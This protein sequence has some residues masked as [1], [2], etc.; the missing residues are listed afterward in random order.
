MPDC[1]VN[2][3][4]GDCVTRMRDCFVVRYPQPHKLVSLH[5]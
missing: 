3:F 2:V 1:V 5:V 4:S